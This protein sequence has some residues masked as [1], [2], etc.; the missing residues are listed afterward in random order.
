MGSTDTRKR[1]SRETAADG[2][3]WL[4][5]I[6]LI[7][8]ELVAERCTGCPIWERGCPLS[9]TFQGLGCYIMV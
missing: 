2:M 5:L 1:P 3:K 8:F 4:F 6:L 7:V 9:F